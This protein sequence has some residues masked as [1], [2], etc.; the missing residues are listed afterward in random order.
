[1]SS[2]RLAAR[3]HL[4]A[5]T[6]RG[7][8]TKRSSDKGRFAVRKRLGRVVLGSF[9]AL[10]A[11]WLA[12]DFLDPLAWALVIAIATWP[13]YRRFTGNSPAGRS[14]LKP[15]IFTLLIGI[16]LILPVSLALNVVAQESGAFLQWL[17]GLRNNGIPL[18]G[19]LDQLPVFGKQAS[20]WWQANLSDPTAVGDWLDSLKSLGSWA[21]A[22]SGEVFDRLF[23][24][25]FALLALF[26]LFQNGDW[27]GDQVCNFAD[28]ILGDPGERLT[29]RML[30]AVRGTVNGTVIV[31]LLEGGLVGIAY[32]VAGVPNPLLLTILTITFAMV[33]FGGWLMFSAASLLLLLQGGSLIWPLL[34]FGFG[35]VVMLIGDNYVWPALVGDAARLPFLLAFIGVFGGLHS[36][37]LIGIFLGPVIM[38]VLLTIWREWLPSRID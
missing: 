23:A 17:G 5:P 25:A 20:I 31:A 4:A 28:Q 33:P 18:P 15:L 32:V 19:W 27:F 12:R 36:F 26:F 3:G 6:E 21:P 30:T 34:V 7:I 10:L 8:V 1:M 38:A 2:D 11:I 22:L 14:F 24:F 37:G 29:G 35:A 16:I 9:V 13:A